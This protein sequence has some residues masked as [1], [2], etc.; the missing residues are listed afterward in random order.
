MTTII[1]KIQMAYAEHYET[2]YDSDYD[3]END[4]VIDL[5]SMTAEER[6]AYDKDMMDDLKSAGEYLMQEYPVY[7]DE[8]EGWQIVCITKDGNVSYEKRENF[9]IYK[10]IQKELNITDI[11]ELSREIREANENLTELWFKITERRA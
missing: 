6:I 7:I 2:F 1:E 10:K 5:P 11:N 8:E 4:K 3:F 9:D